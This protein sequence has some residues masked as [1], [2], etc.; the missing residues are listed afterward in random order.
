MQI[1][2]GQKCLYVKGKEHNLRWQMRN[3]RNAVI[4][5]AVL[6]AGVIGVGQMAQA[7][8]QGSCDEQIKQIQAEIAAS[9]T[10]ADK[11]AATAELTQAQAAQAANNEDDCKQHAE[12]AHAHVNH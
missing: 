3:I 8:L 4:V 9:T 11:D 2:A 7:Q 12:K 10:Q 1:S 6:A 5:A